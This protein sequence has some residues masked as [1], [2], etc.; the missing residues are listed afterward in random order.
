MSTEPQDTE[1]LQ[2]LQRE[3][4]D[5]Q[6]LLASIRLDISHA[7]SEESLGALYWLVQENE[8][9]YL[10]LHDQTQRAALEADTANSAL[11]DAIHAS[12]TDQLTQLP[13]RVV[14]WDR[15]T[16]ELALAKRH[17]TP[18]AVLFL[19]LNDFKAVNDR[20][21]HDVGDLLLLHV[22]I[23]LKATLRASDTVCRLG[24]DEFVIVAG[25]IPQGRL[26]RFVDKIAR[27]VSQPCFVGTEMLTPSVSIGAST[28]PED[29]DLPES[30]LRKADAAMYAS[31]RARVRP[32]D[33]AAASRQI[34]T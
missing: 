13:N 23:T 30:L 2:L 5:A 29:G 15:L 17:A 10:A 14:L 33:P 7:R 26:D 28:F 22:A 19:D 8:R 27:A 12:E 31:K 9:L 32:L 16:H 21:G 24:G 34:S 20:F 4:S 11:Q 1:R 3:I 6:A 18:L 25:D